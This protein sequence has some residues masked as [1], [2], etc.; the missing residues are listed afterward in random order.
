MVGKGERGGTRRDWEFGVVDET[1][2]FEVD[3]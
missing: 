3:K 1:I 2:V